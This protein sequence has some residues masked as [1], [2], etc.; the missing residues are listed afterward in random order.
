MKKVILFAFV[1]AFSLNANANA[2]PELNL[3]EEA[4]QLLP[5]PIPPI[6]F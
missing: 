3:D 5:R 1:M 2:L 4:T 6:R